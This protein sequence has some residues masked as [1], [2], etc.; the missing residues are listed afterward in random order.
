[1]IDVRTV[2]V[3]DENAEAVVGK[4]DALGIEAGVARVAGVV[5]I[6]NGIEGVGSSGKEVEEE[7]ILRGTPEPTIP[8]PEP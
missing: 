6:R 3:G 7:I 8:S 4:P 5:G 2:L 1:L